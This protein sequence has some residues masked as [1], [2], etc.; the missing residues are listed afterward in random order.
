MLRGE[1]HDLT[2][3]ARIPVPGPG[4]P[5]RRRRDESGPDKAGVAGARHR[6]RG[7]MKA[8]MKCS[9]L[10]AVVAA[11]LLAGAA[12]AQYPAYADESLPVW[13]PALNQDTPAEVVF[14]SAQGL[15]LNEEQEPELGG[16]YRQKE[17]RT[18][19]YVLNH[20]TPDDQNIN[21]GE[22]EFFYWV[23]G[24]DG[25]NKCILTVHVFSPEKRMKLSALNDAG[26][27]FV[28]PVT[29]GLRQFNRDEMRF[30]ANGLDNSAPWILSD[31]PISVI[32]GGHAVLD[33]CA[34]RETPKFTH[35]REHFR[36]R[37]EYFAENSEYFSFGS[38]PSTINGANF[39]FDGPL[40][41]LELTNFVRRIVYFNSRGGYFAQDSEYLTREGTIVGTFGRPHLPFYGSVGGPYF[42]TGWG[43]Y[44]ERIGG[45]YFPFSGSFGGAYFGGVGV[46]HPNFHRR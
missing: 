43:P 36:I 41:Q 5:S 10:A 29:I 21:S 28:L 37:R 35:R 16:A 15:V 26:G 14:S 8:V 33:A 40:F 12:R 6:E 9:L 25:D 34:P 38:V 2:V 30:P 23:S 13:S 27:E 45:P 19:E 18:V 22:R 42:G 17:N 1:A 4:L 11:P 24:E 7:D 20:P 3:L 31:Q 32:D 39:V 44:Y 46:T